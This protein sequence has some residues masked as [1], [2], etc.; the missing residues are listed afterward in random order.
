[1]KNKVYTCPQ[2]KFSSYLATI[3]ISFVE[4]KVNVG[5]CVPESFIPELCRF[6]RYCIDY[7]ETDICLKAVTVHGFLKQ[8]T[9]KV[10]TLKRVESILRSLGKYMVLVLRIQDTYVLPK[11][12]KHRW[13]KNF[14][15]YVFS[16]E[17]ISALFVA[18]DSYQLKMHNKPTVNIENCMR[19]II[20]LLYCT[21][22]RVSEACHLKVADVD[23]KNRVIYI[24]HAKNDKH[25]IVTISPSLFDVIQHYLT[26]TVVCDHKESYFFHSGSVLNDGYISSKCVYSYFRKYLKQAGIEHKGTGFGPRLHDLRVTFAVHS[27]KQLTE[28]ETDVNSCLTYLSTYM[29]HQSLQETQDYL[30]LCSDL[31]ESTLF[32]MENY[33]AFI[34]EIFEEKAG[35]CNV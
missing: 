22:M 16:R 4:Y 29:G 13:R 30:W 21:G 7:P 17:E 26:E 15:P 28:K 23:L 11:I 8:R 14:V 12:I 5:G 24:H 32:R 9:I 33:N 31:F 10:S 34:S 20:K 3:F 18:A 19:C 2:G 1:M 6:D 35:E 27:L 25:R